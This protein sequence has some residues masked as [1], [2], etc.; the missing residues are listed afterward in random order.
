MGL[1]YLRFVL[2]YKHVAPMPLKKTGI[3]SYSDGH[4]K[5]VVSAE[6]NNQFDS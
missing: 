4:N 6:Q 5:I 2:S 1:V 3:P